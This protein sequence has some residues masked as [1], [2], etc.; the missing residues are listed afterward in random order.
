MI[1]RFLLILILLPTSVSAGQESFDLDLWA[2]RY[3]LDNDFREPPI[4]RDEVLFFIKDAWTILYRH[5]NSRYFWSS[6][7]DV[8]MIHPLVT[9]AAFRKLFY[10]LPEETQAGFTERSLSHKLHHSALMAHDENARTQFGLG[11]CRG[12]LQFQTGFV[13]ETMLRYHIFIEEFF[14]RQSKATS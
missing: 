8:D 14:R 9:E 4:M 2:D 3:E 11:I 13:S 10:E 12:L 6:L 1:G 5:K 7:F